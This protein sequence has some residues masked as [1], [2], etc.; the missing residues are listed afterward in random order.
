MSA[1]AWMLLRRVVQALLVALIVGTACFFILQALPGDMAYR[2][3]AGR[4]GYDLVNT[5]AAETVRAEL[6]LERPWWQQLVQWWLALAQGDLGRSFVSSEPV[7]NTL[8]N[9]LG[10]TIDL[11][12]TAIVLSLL[13]GP[14]L[15]VAAGLRP[16]G[17]LDRFTLALA[18]VLRTLPPFLLSVLLMLVLSVQLRIVGAGEHG[19]H[20][21]LWLP[22]LAL[23]LGLAA[24]SCRVS[25]EA[26]RA[27]AATPMF[28]FAR[29]KGLSDWQAL[30]RHGLRNAA[31]PVVAYVGVQL[32]FLIEGVVVVETLFAW[33]GIGHALVHAVFGRD[34]PVIQGT[35]LAMG[36][37]FVALNTVIDLACVALDPRRRI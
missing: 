3:A 15:G 18:V 25:R 27:V 28:E 35:A 12:V 23:S 13:I 10:H 37:L 8:T 7:W 11:A 17:W 4:Y 1:V 34:L 20:S 19:E 26:M 9:E 24:G 2:I 16:G 32:V 33:P 21:D 29:T 31:V 14:P 5:A 6:G 22:A 30:W 36:L